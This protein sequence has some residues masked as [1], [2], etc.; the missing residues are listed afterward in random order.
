M[1][2]PASIRSC[3]AARAAEP[4]REGGRLPHERPLGLIVHRREEDYWCLEVPTVY[5]LQETVDGLRFVR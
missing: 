5:V 3:R 1:E 4:T 2:R